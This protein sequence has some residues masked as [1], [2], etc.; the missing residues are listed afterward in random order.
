[1]KNRK[2]PVVFYREGETWLARAVG[3][4]VATFGDDLEEAKRAIRE[5]LELYF[6]DSH[7]PIEVTS[8]H[9]ETVVV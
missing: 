3:V 1:M 9:L 2:V 5:A 8:A 6:E 7:E 4:E